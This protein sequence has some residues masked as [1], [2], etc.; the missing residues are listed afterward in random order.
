MRSK[1]WILLSRTA[2][3][4]LLCL[5]VVPIALAQSED[6]GNA[7]LD[8]A[9]EAKIDA[10]STRDLDGVV[11]L[12]ESA[13]EKGLNNERTLQAKQLA[14]SALYEH[15]D[16]LG[17]RIFGSGGQ[18][19]RWRFLRNQALSRLKKA[20]EFQPEMG[21]AYVLSA[22]LNALPG[23][24]RTDALAMI[25]KAVELAGDDQEQLSTALFYRATLATDENAQ[26]GD[27]NQAIKIN[28]GNIEAIR[29]RAVYYLQKR[30]PKKALPDLRAWMDS[31]AKNVEIKLNVVRQL[32]GTEKFDSDLQK[33]A[34][35]IIDEAI[36]VDPD[37]SAAFTIRAEINVEGEKLEDA[38][39]D[40]S[41][42]IKLDQKN[43]AALMV[44]ARIY[45]VQEELEKAL[46]DINQVL[47][48]QPL[49]TQGLW[50]RGI[51]LSQQQK[52]SEAI[53]DIK[54]L[55]D[56][57]PLNDFFQSQLAMLYN[58][59]D[60]PSK[61]VRIYNRLLAQLA[62]GIWEGE[63]PGR[64]IALMT[65][66]MEALRG[67]GDA[68]LSKG[69]HKE[70]IEDYEAAL[71]L[72]DSIREVQEAEGV[73]EI[74][75]PDD[76]V[77][78]NL[79]WVLATSTFDELRDGKRA[80][81]LATKAAEVTE[82]NQA[83]ILSTLA[84]GYA[85]AG[86]FDKAIEWIEKAIELNRIAGEKA[87]DK[88]RTDKQKLSLRKEYESYQEKKPWREFQDVENEKKETEAKEDKAG[89]GAEDSKSEP[90]STDKEADKKTENKTDDGKKDDKK[91]GGKKADGKDDGKKDE[92]KTDDKKD[93][94]KD[95]K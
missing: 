72:A 14:A 70:A 3:T 73:E 61:A 29:V 64:Q 82:F 55:A 56:S 21:E 22:K 35:T 32:M 4:I 27:L 19:K 49:Q 18:D 91:D 60:E 94:K 71:E 8:K 47:E 63:L 78:N 95:D 68:Q 83:H 67:R 79:A 42:A 90:K 51:I 87:V 65:A 54:K 89:S 80:I 74:M 11:S 45:S 92:G 81:E 44:R 46:E 16:Q 88:T 66:R 15:A 1:D 62:D 13:I 7:D 34:L 31:D 43:T 53:D 9:F 40:A 77:L 33:E 86:D 37:N 69:A 50:M 85:E 25:E 59:N 38:I 23:G 6:E 41:R 2:L 20:I 12:C 5:L 10:R 26:L 24:D 76:G 93:D 58:A 17:Q 48:I 28:P 57:D 52:F 39:K 36:E 30:E 75:E 84:S